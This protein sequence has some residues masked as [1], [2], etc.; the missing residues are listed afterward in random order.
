[1]RVP[2]WMQGCDMDDMDDMGDMGDMG[3]MYD[4]Y[5]ICR[6]P[7]CITLP[8]PGVLGGHTFS[9]FA[10]ARTQRH[11]VPSSEPG[12]H[13]LRNVFGLCCFHSER[14]AYVGPPNGEKKKVGPPLFRVPHA[15]DW[16]HCR[17]MLRHYQWWRTLHPRTAA[18]DNATYLRAK[19]IANF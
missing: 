16:A 7:L 18:T 12:P 17:A 14:S 3:D 19:T 5:D 10:T 8:A 11:F 15:A 4:M 1:M 6:R 2:P 9:F 13:N